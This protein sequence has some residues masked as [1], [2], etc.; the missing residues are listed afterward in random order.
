[1]DGSNNLTFAYGGNVRMRITSS[2]DL[3]VEDDITAFANI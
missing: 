1:V 2:G 3:E